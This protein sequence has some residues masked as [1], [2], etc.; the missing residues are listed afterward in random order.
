M[1]LELEAAINKRRSVRSYHDREVSPATV[2]RLLEAAVM[3]PSA[4]N[5]QAWHFVVA[6]RPEAR[7]ALARAALDQEFIA[8]APVVVVVCADPERSATRYG[9]RGRTLYC[10]QD[11]AAATQNLL[12]AATAHGLGTCWVGAFD[13]VRVREVLG[14]PASL[15]P[16]ALVPVG[17]PAEAPEAR[18]RRPL[19]EVT[20]VLD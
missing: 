12:L 1:S 8:Q 14:I 6:R 7:A 10:L 4:G 9:Q 11:A 13:E 3:A 5:L 17:Y 20:T 18:P 2:T 15:R 16:V 19:E